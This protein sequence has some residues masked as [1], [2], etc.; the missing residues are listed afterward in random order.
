M[1]PRRLSI[2]SFS[3]RSTQKRN[4]DR[5][6]SLSKTGIREEPL[7]SIVIPSRN[8]SVTIGRCLQSIESQSY[9][10]ME[11]IVVDNFSSD[12]TVEIVEGTGT[13]VLTAGPERS[14]QVNLG[15][16]ASKGKYVYRVDSDFIVGKEVV[17][18]CVESCEK[19]A[20]DGIAVHNTSD[21]T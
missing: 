5:M 14:R 20:L 13:K 6:M 7:V 9:R 18:E 19:C 11:V 8:S 16:S 4:Q 12:Q 2:L 1:I 10:N 15:V 3:R 21:P 17:A